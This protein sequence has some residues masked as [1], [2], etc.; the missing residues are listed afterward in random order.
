MR[1]LFLTAD[2][3]GFLALGVLGTAVTV[4]LA[5]VYAIFPLIVIFRLGGIL[6]RLDKSRRLR[7]EAD[8]R[9]IECAT[10]QLQ[11]S[12]ELIREQKAG[13]ALMRQ[14]LRTYGHEPEA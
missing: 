3:S 5:I 10:T 7:Q 4:V 14:L 12:T 8:Q 9:A 1:I 2:P 11:A 6:S 13:N